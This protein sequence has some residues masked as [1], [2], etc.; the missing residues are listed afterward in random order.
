MQQLVQGGGAGLVH[1]R[2]HRHLNRFQIE[3]AALA[4]S[5]ENDTPEVIYFARDLLTDRFSRFFSC[6]VCRSSST[7]RKPQISALV[8]TNSRL[9]CWNLRNSA[10]S[11]SALWMAA[12]SGKESV[13]V[14]PSDL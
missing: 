11:R 7:G 3:G 13:M 2:A 4:P 10:T 5:L 12:A 8:S 9:S 6:S 1:G 14:L